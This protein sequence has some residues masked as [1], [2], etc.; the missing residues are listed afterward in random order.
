M[1]AAVTG[2]GNTPRPRRLLVKVSWSEIKLWVGKL[3]NLAGYP[4]FVRTCE[5]HSEGLGTT[6]SVKR[7]ELYTLISVNG[8]DV[9]FNRFTGKIDGLG[10]TPNAGCTAPSAKIP[11]S[12]HP[13]EPPALAGPSQ[14]QMRTVEDLHEPRRDSLDY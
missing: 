4:L 5:Y 14:P 11:E 8:T 7:M 3:A 10:A 12:G 6:V 13:D 9:Y 2:Q 1:I